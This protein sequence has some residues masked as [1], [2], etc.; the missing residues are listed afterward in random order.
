MLL[1]IKKLLY[2]EFFNR[3]VNNGIICIYLA[4]ITINK[5]VITII[6]DEV[7]FAATRITYITLHFIIIIIYIDIIS[8]F[9]SPFKTIII[10][11]MDICIVIVLFS[12]ILSK[13]LGLSSQRMSC[14]SNQF[15]NLYLRFF[16]ESNFLYI[17]LI[18]FTSWLRV[19]IFFLHWM[20]KLLAFW[21]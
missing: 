21:Q 16:N 12:P 15:Y 10:N 19:F 3:F 17:Y 14:T 9:S 7:L 5:R 8:T 6:V 4:I 1:Q 20:I 11:T 2:N 18:Y 13:A